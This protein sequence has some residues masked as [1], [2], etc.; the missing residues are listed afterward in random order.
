[1][2]FRLARPSCLVDINDVQGLW[3]I[4][5]CDGRVKIGATTRQRHTATDRGVLQHL[6]LLAEAIGYMG[7]MAIQNRGT[8]GGSIAHADPA[9]ELPVIA[10]ALDASMHLQRA[11]ATRTVSAEAFF[12]GYLSTVIEPDELLTS[13]AFCVPPGGSGWCF[14]EIARR[15]GDFALVA[16]ATVLTP[17]VDGRIASARIAF[18]GV[19]PTPLRAYAAEQ[20]LLGEVPMD[21]VFR[22]AAARAGDSLDPTDDLHASADYRRHLAG[23]LVR[24]ALTTAASRATVTLSL[25]EASGEGRG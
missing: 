23:V 13:V 12:T 4:G 2:N 22:E 25:G 18:G 21:E 17:G 14:T 16:V 15:H 6:P 19:G 11:D 7:H 1:M 5:W 10:L 8:I 3:G 24:R 9:A 20:A